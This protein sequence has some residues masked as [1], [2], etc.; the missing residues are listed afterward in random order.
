VTDHLAPP[1]PLAAADRCVLC[2][3]CLPHCPTYRLA[4]DENESPRGRISLLR[5]LA[6]H[7]LALEA[8]VIRHLSRCLDCRACERVC[9]SGVAYGQLIAAGR[10]LCHSHTRSGF[11]VR[12]LLWMTQRRAALGLVT[13]MVQGLRRAGIL[14]LLGGV[15]P[16]LRIAALLAA[17]PITPSQQQPAPQANTSARQR[18]VLFHGCLTRMLDADTLLSAERVLHH[19]G[20]EIIAPSEQACCGGL[21]RDNGDPETAER[22]CAQNRQVLSVP[23]A[24]AIVTLAS[25]CGARLA[26]DLKLP[27]LP[28]LDIHDYLATLTLPDTLEL[29][30]L[31]QRVAVQDPCSL[32]N[33]LR[34]EQGVYTL[35]RRIPGLSVEPLAE[36]QFC[37]GGA[38]LYPLRE[39]EMA[40]RLRAPKLTALE[41]SRPDVLVSA[42]LGCALHLAAGLHERRL[43]IPVLHPLVLFARQLRTRGGLQ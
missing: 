26:Q 6:T 13:A 33:S 1:F 5:A 4:Q 19:L 43:A 18:V 38:G 24:E 9:P 14:R 31:H 42:N 41:Q 32:R 2:G 10:V 36:N 20:V 40:E 25:G 37:C 3:L 21:H 30:P 23:G 39:A 34:A 22:L 29:A 27:G 11:F 8:R 15:F 7:S 16:R 17:L 12:G 35:L 28:V